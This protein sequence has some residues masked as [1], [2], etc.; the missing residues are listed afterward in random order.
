M[1]WRPS[2]GWLEHKNTEAY[3]SRH[4][5]H[6][7]TL[8]VF[9][10]DSIV[11]KQISLNALK[12][13]NAMTS[14]KQ[15]I[16]SRPAAIVGAGRVVA[17][18]WNDG[19]QQDSEKYRFTFFRQSSRTGRVRQSFRPADLHDL[20]KLC[21]AVAALVAEDTSIPSP[22]QQALT[23]LADKLDAITRTRN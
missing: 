13:T 11:P 19:D 10:I 22:Q 14:T 2:Q 8:H 4:G 7:T 3:F 15:P 5:E 17:T 12:R 6:V 21:Q 16:L 9:P 1:S 23:D 18:L 20:V